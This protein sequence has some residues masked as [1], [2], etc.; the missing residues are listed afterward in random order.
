MFTINFKVLLFRT[1]LNGSIYAVV[2]VI[3][4]FAIKLLVDLIRIVDFGECTFSKMGWCQ[5]IL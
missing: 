1:L 2:F 3:F 5:V 4:I